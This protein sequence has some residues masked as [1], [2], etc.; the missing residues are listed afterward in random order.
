MPCKH[1]V[2]L[3]LRLDAAAAQVAS[4]IRLLEDLRTF[5]F[6]QLLSARAAC[7]ESL[8]LPSPGETEVHETLSEGIG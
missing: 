8:L 5:A 7:T 2:S 3:P 1:V 4:R 6:C